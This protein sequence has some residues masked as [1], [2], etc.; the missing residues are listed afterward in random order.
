MLDKLQSIL[1]KA[2]AGHRYIEDQDQYGVEEYWTIDL[3][4]DCEDFALWCRQ[5]LKKIGIESN[6]ILCK[7][8]NGEGHLVCDV[9]GWILDNRHYHVMPKNRLEYTWLKLGRPDGRW[10]EI[11][12]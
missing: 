2:H 1:N 11:I 6:L 7:T 9:E 3:R 12:G 4:G 8:E 5:E 10:Y